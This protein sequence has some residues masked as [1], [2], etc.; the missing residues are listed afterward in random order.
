MERDALNLQQEEAK[1][2]ESVDRLK[3]QIV[4][5]ERD[6]QRQV[7]PSLILKRQTF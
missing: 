1:G 5:C 6:L 3:E 7:F 2:K 4:Q